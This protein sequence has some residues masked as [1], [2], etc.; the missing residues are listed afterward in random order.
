MSQE[1]NKSN[2]NGKVK[3]GGPDPEVAG[4]TK[5]R[6]FSA[7]EKVRILKEIEQCQ[8]GQ[9]GAILRREGIYS[10]HV[11]Q[12]R[13]QQAKGQL[14]ALGGQKRGRPADIQAVELAQLRR[15]NERLKGQLE[16]AELIIEVQ[17]KV[18]QLFGLTASQ[19]EQDEQ[20]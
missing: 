10:S 3:L 8:P 6:Q 9:I 4:Q 11:S 1:Q 7:A 13:R 18:S 19:M 16:R 2:L 20:S 17:K 15:E 5:R 12:W 14:T